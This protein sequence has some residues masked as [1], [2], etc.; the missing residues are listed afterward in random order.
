M[1]YAAWSVVFGEQP[2]ASKWNILGSNDAAFADGSGISALATNVTAVSNPYKFF[3]YSS[4]SQSSPSGAAFKIA[5]KSELYDTNNNFDSTTNYRYTVPVTGFYHVTASGTITNGAGY[6]MDTWLYKNGSSL[7][8]AHY[9]NGGSVADTTAVVSAL[10]SLTAADYLEM[11]VA[12][13][14]G[15]G[16]S[17]PFGSPY[18]NYMSGYLVS[19]T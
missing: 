18:S 13:G 11:F 7:L 4:A 12:T 10:L 16:A 5:L 15:A 2:S 9:V 3:A 19:R 6:S 17:L 1:A 14:F 8:N